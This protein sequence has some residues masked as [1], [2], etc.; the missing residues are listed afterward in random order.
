MRPV[1]PT[2]VQ[3]LLDQ[4]PR[5]PL[6]SMNR[7]PSIRWP[8]SRTTDSMN[9]DSGLHIDIDHLSLGSSDSQPSLIRRRS[10]AYKLAS[11]VIGIICLALLLVAEPVGLGHAR[12]KAE[13]SSG[14]CSPCSRP[15]ASNGGTAPPRYRRHGARM[16]E[17]NV[18]PDAPSSGTRCPA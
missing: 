13:T 10:A 3:G 14:A 5:K 2:R 4:Q 7:S 12:F 18:L 9:P 17:N 8:D 15:A 6:Q 11:K 16:G 1:L